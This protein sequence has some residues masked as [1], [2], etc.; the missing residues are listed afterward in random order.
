MIYFW[1][2]LA[3]VFIALLC[4]KAYN[5]THIPYDRF[6]LAAVIIWP[7]M[8]VVIIFGSINDWLTK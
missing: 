5:K 8:I 6:P 2:Y 7:V 4:A 1:I 3:S